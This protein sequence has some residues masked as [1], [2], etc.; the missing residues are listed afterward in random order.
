MSVQVVDEKI[1]LD[2]KKYLVSKTDTHGIIEYANDY[3]IEVSGY[4]ETELIGKSHSIVRHPDTPKVIFKIMWERIQEGENFLAIIK[5]R[6]KD[7]RYYWI[8]T[9]FEIN[10]DKVTNKP[11]SYVAYRQAASDKIITQIE[12]LY[13]K[14]VELEKSGDID[15]SQKYLIGYL[16]EKGK[17][18]DEYM[19][20]LIGNNKG[21]AKKFFSGV[22]GIFTRKK[23]D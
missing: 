3:F 1:V 23:K 17:S 7:G 15:M 9:D 6:A 14:L 5:N 22:K 11:I 19:E 8:F 2:P 18:Y 13:K 16:E 21:M 20:Q 12:P 4:S 10:L